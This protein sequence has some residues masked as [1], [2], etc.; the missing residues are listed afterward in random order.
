[1]QAAPVCSSRRPHR[2]PRRVE[3]LDQAREFQGAPVAA[4][5]ANE[6]SD[7]LAVTGLIALCCLLLPLSGWW[8]ASRLRDESL[9]RFTAACLIGC[10]CLA[11][12]ELFVVVSRLP[13]WVAAA[14]VL[15]VCVVSLRP[16]IRAI[17]HREFAWD[18]LLTWAG[19][20]CVLAAATARF[21]VHGTPGAQW[22]WYEHWERA[23]LFFQQGELIQDRSYLVAARGPILNAAAAMIFEFVGSQHYWIFQIVAT[24]FNAMVCLPFAMFLHT[25]AGVSRRK[26]L[27]IAAAVMILAPQFFSDNTFTWTK[28]LTAAFVLLAIHEYLVAYRRG[29]R[30]GM[31]MSLTYLAPAFLTH[32]LAMMYAVLLGLHL[33]LVVPVRQFPMKALLRTAMVWALLI[34]PWFGFMMVHFGIAPTLR[35]NSTLGNYYAT[36]DA[37]G[38]LVPLYR[39]YAANL[40]VDL[41]SRAACRQ[42]MAPPKPCIWVRMEGDKVTQE[43]QPCSP[44]MDLGGVAVSLRYSGA[45]AILLAI[46]VSFRSIVHGLR[47]IS[48]RVIR[49]TA[50][51]RAFWF[52]AWVLAA[53]LFLNLLPVRWFDPWGTIAENLQAWLLVLIALSLR[54]LMRLPRLALLALALIFA[55]ECSYVDLELIRMQSIVLPF[56]HRGEAALGHP[57]LSI[58][59]PEPVRLGDVFAPIEYLHNYRTKVLGEA[60]FFRDLHPDD[61]AWF[62][63]LF[64]AAGAFWIALGSRLAPNKSN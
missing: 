11:C 31:A 58:E 51:G 59:P 3:P 10:T 9:F 63:W 24:T 19:I 57:P 49:D 34:G 5:Y 45:F 44:L 4:W 7:A 20:A 17:R 15:A 42:L 29:D 26:A 27:L 16:V 32:Y 60:V 12:A 35:A 56:S 8:L 43:E 61:F 1:M 50:A 55:L 36:K 46:A 40:C 14:M 53:G 54:G 13:Q 22:D 6:L 39:I 21:A 64:L 37:Q 25:V 41:F 23:L 30:N 52:I 48:L 47:G 62:S 2:L 33:L 18:A 38:R 28:D